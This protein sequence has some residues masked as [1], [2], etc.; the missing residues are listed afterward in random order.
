MLNSRFKWLSC[1]K[2]FC[3][4][5]HLVDNKTNYSNTGDTQSRLL[6]KKLA[7]N[8]KKQWQTTK[9]QIVN[10]QQ[11]SRP[12]TSLNFGHMSASF[13]HRIELCSIWCKIFVQEKTCTRKHDTQ[14]C[15]LYKSTCTR[16]LT[17]CHQHKTTKNV[18]SIDVSAVHLNAS[19]SVWQTCC[20]GIN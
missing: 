1:S 14:S 17:V 13:F 15:F 11:I 18:L 9:Q 19:Y 5:F 3:K 8:D 4:K 20:T 16:F 2:Q 12:I 7:S 6:Y 10:S